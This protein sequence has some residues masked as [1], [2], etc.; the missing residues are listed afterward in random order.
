[1]KTKNHVDRNNRWTKTIRPKRNL[2]DLRLG[3]LWKSRDMVLLFVKRDFVAVY[4]Q[5]ILGPLWY[6]LQPLM[7]TIVFTFIFG[8]IAKLPTDGL[9]SFV[10]YMSGTVISS[11]FSPEVSVKGFIINIFYQ[12]TFIV[13]EMKL[14]A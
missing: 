12:F 9:P 3:E 7:T 6:I 14:K 11:Y 2:L 5:T 4:K 8:N 1:M 10:F 13:F